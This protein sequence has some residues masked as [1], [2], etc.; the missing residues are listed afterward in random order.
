MH[1]ELGG[2]C[3]YLLPRGADGNLLEGLASL[4]HGFGR[5]TG[6]I[7]VSR[8]TGWPA[9]LLLSFSSVCALEGLAGLQHT[10]PERAG[11]WAM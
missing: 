9:E 1:R 7:H 11:V 4:P 2:P 6:T 3:F 5:T 10:P 8:G